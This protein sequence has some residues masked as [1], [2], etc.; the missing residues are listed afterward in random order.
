MTDT[1]QPTR[2][3]IAAKDRSGKLTV[4]GKLKVALDTMLYQ[5]SC[6]AVAAKAAGMTDHGLREAFKK[7]HVK[8]FYNAGLQILRDSERA[9]NIHRAVEIRDAAN[10]QP[11]IQAIR[12]LEDLGD[13]HGGRFNLNLGITLQAG[14]VID[15]RDDA[16]Q[17]TRP[18]PII[19]V[20]PSAP[21]VTSVFSSGARR[22]SPRPL[23]PDPQP[24]PNPVFKGPIDREPWD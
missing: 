10:N 9:R 19:D 5:G 23:A 24:D 12:L 13:E 17:T 11:A 22:P 8:A 6:R 16:P 1:D 7:P 18:A 15:I 3:A 14:Y 2:Q 21:S 4:S 20:T